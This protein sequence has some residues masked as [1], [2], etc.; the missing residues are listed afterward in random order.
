VNGSQGHESHQQNRQSDDQEV[1]VSIAASYDEA[2]SPGGQHE[3]ELKSDTGIC[4]WEEH[5]DHPMRN[6]RTALFMPEHGT[7]R[8]NTLW[9]MRALRKLGP[10]P[11][12][13]L[14]DIP[15]PEVGP[16]EVLIEVRATSICGTDLHIYEWN[17]W[18]ADHVSPPIT[19][20]HE[21]TGVVVDRGAN[22]IEPEIGQLVS[23]ESHV[24]CNICAWCRTGQGHLCPKTQILGVHRDGAYAEYVVVPAQNAWPDPPNMSLSIASLQENFGNAVHTATVPSI[25]GRKVLVTGSGPVGAMAIA[26]AKALGARAVYATD[27]SDYRLDLA[28]TMGADRTINPLREDVAAVIAEA[29]ESEGV[30][31]L[32][33]MSGAPSALEAGFAALKPGGEAALLGLTSE[34]FPFDIDDNIIFK[35]ATVYGIVGRRLWQTWLEM[36]GLI[37]S[38]AVDLAPVITH[39]F[40]LDDYEKA[41]ELM[42]SGECGKVI[43]FPDLTYADGPLS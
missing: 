13:D 7:P 22:V 41:F 27:I 1:N 37:R 40:A 3:T 35:G 21:L 12:F 11:G 18:A 29:T 24:V 32:L 6:A 4:S 28:T 10:G 31:V 17:P 25:A 36:R 43:M 38:G 34:K 42:Q 2:D 19:V 8:R 33:E 39:R 20:G 15:I 30:D 26:V 16:E 9:P 5:I 23:A 14:V